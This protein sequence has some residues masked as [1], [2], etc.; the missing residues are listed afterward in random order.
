LEADI[1]YS[2]FADDPLD[3][4]EQFL[5]Q[6]QI[7]FE[8]ISEYEVQF[9]VTGTWC[10]YPMW[11]RWL[12]VQ[13]M[14]QVGLGIEARIPQNRRA[15]TKDLVVQVNERLIIGNFDMWSADGTLVFRL[16]QLVESGNT[17]SEELAAKMNLAAIEAAEMLVPALNLLLWS[18]KTATQAVEAAMFETMGEA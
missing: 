14:V 13:A 3:K 8:R 18:E 6:E 1:Q 12:P 16:G 5:V 9:S 15:E 7:L 17:V 4:V 2:S 10:D 11:F